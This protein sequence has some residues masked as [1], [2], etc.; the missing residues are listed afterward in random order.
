VAS[1]FYTTNFWPEELWPEGFWG[2]PSAVITGSSGLIV[3][4]LGGVSANLVGDF[5][6]GESSGI[7]V[8]ALAGVTA[9]FGGTIAYVTN[10]DLDL[11]ISVN[12]TLID[13]PAV[14]GAISVT[15]GDD[16]AAF[17]GASWEGSFT[18]GVLGLYET[19]WPT[20]FWDVR[21]F[22]DGY[23]PKGGFLEDIASSIEGSFSD[24][25]GQYT[26][27]IATALDPVTALLSGRFTERQQFNGQ[28]LATLD[29]ATASL[30]GAS[31]RPVFAGAIYSDFDGVS[32]SIVGLST[33]AGSYLGQVRSTLTGVAGQLRG[34]YRVLSRDGGIYTVLEDLIGEALGIAVPEGSKV[35]QVRAGLFGVSMLGDGTF[36][37]P[38]MRAKPDV[39]TVTEIDWKTLCDQHNLGLPEEVDYE[40]S[41]GR[42]FYQS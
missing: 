23:W 27:F 24:A 14:S 13:Q 39:P 35:G 33:L 3:A 12:T 31:E 2:D 9:S 26:S 37:T 10:F 5:G 8:S 17:A 20:T 19:L 36:V 40:F 29:G 32:S 4:D 7:L 38:R 16:S 21:L 11:N 25:P 15:L 1:L 34:E 42:R 30:A 6:A 22:P 41:N 28:L 18:G